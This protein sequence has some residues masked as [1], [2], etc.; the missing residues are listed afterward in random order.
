[1]SKPQS[2]M[3][4]SRKGYKKHKTRHGISPQSVNAGKEG[5]QS[6]V[7]SSPAPKRSSVDEHLTTGDADRHRYAIAE[8]KRSL[9]IAAFVFAVLIVLYFLL[10]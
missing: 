6:V 4:T 7:A 5:C 1:M 10:R 3:K 9:L 2:T 8:L